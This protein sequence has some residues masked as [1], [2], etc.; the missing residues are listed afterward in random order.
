MITTSH[1][2][3]GRSSLRFVYQRGQSVRAAQLSLRYVVNV[4]RATYRVAVVVSRK[5]SKSAVVRN[6]IRRRIYEIIRS[7]P[8]LTAKPFDLVFSVYGED[9]ARISHANLERLVRQLLQKADVVSKTVQP[10]NTHGIVE[11]KETL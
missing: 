8:D 1:R 9:V 11:S 2:F 3:K 5:T 6:R 4:R 10:G 7:Q